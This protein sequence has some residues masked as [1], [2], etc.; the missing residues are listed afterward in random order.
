M[1]K[2]IW[3]EKPPSNSPGVA[4]IFMIPFL[5]DSVELLTIYSWPVLY[6]VLLLVLSGCML[7][8]F[9][10]HVWWTLSRGF[11]LSI[12]ATLKPFFCFLLTS[13]TGLLINKSH[14]KLCIIVTVLLKAMY[15]FEM[16][17]FSQRY[18]CSYSL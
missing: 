1:Q 7:S 18:Y 16:S 17:A 11:R 6:F 12:L 10:I 3:E 15:F 5:S 4:L 8:V 2:R 13:V 14:M 9:R